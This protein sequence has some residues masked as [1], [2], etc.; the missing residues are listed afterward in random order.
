MYDVRT[1]V[2]RDFECGGDGGCGGGH[3]GGSDCDGGGI[4]GCLDG[5]G[6]DGATS[7]FGIAIPILPLMS[8]F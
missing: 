4:R 2:I 7:I 5:G 1:P 8:S 6:C 3:D